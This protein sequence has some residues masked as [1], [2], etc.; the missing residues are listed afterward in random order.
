MTCFNHSFRCLSVAVM[1]FLSACAT[2]VVNDKPAI[3]SVNAADSEAEPKLVRVEPVRPKIDLTGD[4]MYRI[5]EAEFA[6]QRGHIETSLTNYSA[7]AL[8]TRD[9]KIVERATRIA[10]YARETEVAEEMANLWTDLD[11]RN[12][13]PHQVLAVMALRNGDVKSSLTH[14]ES[15]LDYTYGD[16]EQKLLMVANLLGREGDKDVIIEVM[17][18][19]MATRQDSP[20]VLFAFS[21]VATI[22][23][24][25]DFALELMEMTYQ[26]NPEDDTVALGYV[27]ILQRTGRLE[28]AISWL[29]NVIRKRKGDDF[30]LRMNYARLLLESRMYDEARQQFENLISQKPDNPDVMFSLGLLYLQSGQVDDADIYFSSLSKSGHRSNE[31]NYY[32]GRIAEDRDDL[33]KAGIWYQGVQGGPNYFDSQIRLGLILAKQNRLEDARL[34]LSSIRTQ[35]E[36]ESV[37]LV[38]AEAGLLVEEEEYNEAMKIYDRAIENGYN[39]DLLYSRAMLAEKI[40]RL[41]IS[42]ADLRH[43]IKREPENSQALNALGYTLADRTERYEEAE[44]LIDQ[45]IEVSPHDHYILDSKGWVLYRMGKLEEAILYL[46]RALDIIP[47]AEIAAHLGEVL[48]VKGDK[49]EASKVWKTA[50][51]AA[52]DNDLLK[53]IIQRFNP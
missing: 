14:L 12:P 20:E 35:N 51:K 5:L 7:L 19:L 4:L 22:L 17:N 6:G 23:G 37:V 18:K 1:I 33:V 25:F 29:E 38:Q 21:R 15:I 40:D 46:R 44:Q 43:I 41:D 13:D 16:V 8:E 42:E 36:T 34:H 28:E 52:P 47:D 9:P 49:K 3:D 27:A 26:L 50:L 10:V 11:P 45:A 53:D 32:L 2:S 48:W 31:V 39:S 30:D 24:E